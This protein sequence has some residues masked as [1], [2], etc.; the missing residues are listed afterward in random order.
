MWREYFVNE[1]S[2]SSLA[3]G[4]G[5]AFEDSTIKIDID[6]DFEIIKR[7]H[8]AIDNK[9]LVEFKDDS[10]GRFYQNVAMD[11][12][13]IS[14]DHT[15][16]PFIM[17]F[18]PF[19]V[20]SPILIRAATTYTARFSDYSTV[21]NSIR[22]ALH[23]TKIRRGVAP[24]DKPFRARLAFDYVVS[25]TIA[26]SSTVVVNV[27]INIDS[28]FLVKKITG[29]RTGEAN[30]SI[31]DSGTD[32]FWSNT[33]VHINNIMGSGM[34]PNVLTAPR[35]IH[36]GTSLSVQLQDLSGSSNTIR[37]VFSGE[38]LFD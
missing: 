24:W 10:A 13:S 2:D 5:V 31:K 26:A 20:A 34:Y 1:V 18:Q 36:P 33:P 14:S 19:K 12:T 29:T 7:S 23:G 16:S 37:M 22:L 4:T 38:K 3:A 30:V 28:S 9:I 32:R 15:P 25:A 8:V 6:A 35:F 27:P 21:A 11:V 17:M